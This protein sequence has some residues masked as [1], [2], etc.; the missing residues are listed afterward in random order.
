MSPKMKARDGQSGAA[1]LL[2]T[3]RSISARPTQSSRM[4]C[5]DN[6]IR[7]SRT[8]SIACAQIVSHLL[9]KLR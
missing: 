9:L 6:W 7:S 4:T 1:A 3:T 2:A 5:V 8:F